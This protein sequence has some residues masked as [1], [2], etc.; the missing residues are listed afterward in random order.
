MKIFPYRTAAT[1]WKSSMVAA[2]LALACFAGV[3]RSAYGQAEPTATRFGDLKVG[4]TFNLADS[5]YTVNRFRGF[6]FYTNFDFRY[7]LGLEAEFHQLNNSVSSPNIYERTYEI[8][9]RYVLHYG[10]LQPY[11]KA[12]YGRGVFNYPK[13]GPGL[14]ANIAY[15][16]VAFGGGADYSL[17]RFLTVRAGYEY[18]QWMGFPPHGLTPAMLEVGAAYH[19]H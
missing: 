8:G 11:A 19:F 18:Q 6:G 9:P 13:V 3:G 16:L 15:N 2:V 7:H 10:R 5:D 14:G 12:L 1:C 4:G 17:T